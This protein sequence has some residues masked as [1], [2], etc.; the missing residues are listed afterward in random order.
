MPNAKA[1]MYRLLVAYRVKQEIMSREIKF[2]FFKQH[3]KEMNYVEKTG[4][5]SQ[6]NI[7]SLFSTYGF[8]ACN[9]PMQFT[10]IEDKN[11]KDIYEGDI[12]L[13]NYGGHRMKEIVVFHTGGFKKMYK[14]SDDENHY[15]PFTTLSTN[16]SEVIGNIYENPELLTN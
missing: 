16:R 10:G 1:E 9:I 4:V 12:L 3:T 5:P 11:D 15:L 14:E 8:E 2:R 7:N 6:T 13:V